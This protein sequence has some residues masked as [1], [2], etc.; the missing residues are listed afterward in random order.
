M[1]PKMLGF[2]H[3]QTNVVLQDLL[4]VAV[5]GAL[6]VGLFLPCLNH[7]SL[8]YLFVR[9]K[10]CAELNQGLHCDVKRPQCG[11]TSFR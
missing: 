8:K 5:M 7:Y 10:S 2:F 6:G 3:V 9:M 4:C 11:Q 1:L